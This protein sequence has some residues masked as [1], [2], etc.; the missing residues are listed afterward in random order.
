MAPGEEPRYLELITEPARHRFEEL[1]FRHAGYLATQPMMQAE[2][3]IVQLVMRNDETRTLA[4]F[5]V[6]HPFA[7]A[8]PSA[9]V[10]ESFL[11]DGTVF[12]TSARLMPIIGP[13]LPN[14]RRSRAD[15]RS[16]CT[17]TTW[18]LSS[19]RAGRRSSFPPPSKDWSP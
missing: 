18:R 7:E 3:E 11:P 14:R 17:A 8:R 1:G 10:F 9:V 13:Q 5:Y 15:E 4:Y 19:A 2:R 12:A 16:E 6:R